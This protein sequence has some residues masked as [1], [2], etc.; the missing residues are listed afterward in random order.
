[1]NRGYNGE[2]NTLPERKRSEKYRR[3]KLDP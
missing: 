1:M 3:D 2:T